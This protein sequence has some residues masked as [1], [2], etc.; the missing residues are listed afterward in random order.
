MQLKTSPTQRL[1]A[2]FYFLLWTLGQFNFA[3]AQP[4][5]LVVAQ[6]APFG[7]PLAGAARDYNLGA[8]I[9]FHEVNV[10]GGIGGA[11]IRLVSRDDGYRS[12]EAVMHVKR[13]LSD[14]QGSEPIAFIGMWG[15]DTVQAIL[16]A[17][18]LARADVPVVGIRSGIN[19]Q[20][21]VPQLFHIRA[22]LLA[23]VDRMLAQIKNT[24]L[25]RVA[26][27]YEDEPFGREV[28]DGIS[29]LLQKHSLRST[30]A[31]K[32]NYGQQNANQ[33]LD[34]LGGTDAQ[35]L[36]LVANTPVAGAVI[37]GL[38]GK[39]E[40]LRVYVTSS[41][42]AER[43]AK[44]LGAKSAGVVVAQGVPN[45]YRITTPIALGFTDRLRRLGI[46]FAR[47]NFASMEGYLAAKVLVKA[48]KSASR[49]GR[50]VTRRDVMKALQRMQA[51]DIRG[52]RVS[53]DE[54]NREG[55]QFVEL[56][57]IGGDGR[58]RQ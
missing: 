20:R 15:A 41:A 9:A 12:A 30:L 28:A 37:Q 36:L 44:Q 18:D 14:E 27:I 40:P 56:S 7:G 38:K 22:S 16:D 4:K 26:L 1:L 19:T 52:F 10:R 55:S 11:Q 57:V 25:Q 13:L 49:A 54:K 51:V 50:D 2:T 8:L 17:G 53:F 39:L 46:D 23:E 5:E 24:G 43:L 3:W 21:K 35:A 34:A 32:Q 45:P 58:V 29:A 33:A 42:D 48:M 31:F 6:V 47:A